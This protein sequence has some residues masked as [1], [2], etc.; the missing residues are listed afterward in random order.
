[1]RWT[2]LP[3][4]EDTLERVL[5]RPRPGRYAGSLGLYRPREATAVQ[6]R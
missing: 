1:L 3:G 2:V 5:H 4:H 6:A